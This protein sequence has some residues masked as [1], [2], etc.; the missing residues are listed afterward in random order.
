MAHVAD[1]GRVV[2]SCTHDRADQG[3]DGLAPLRPAAIG[4]LELA[5][6]RE[7]LGELPGAAAEVD[8]DRVTAQQVGHVRK[9]R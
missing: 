5:V 2:G 1:R 7:E 8:P 4:K 9:S 3:G 6:A